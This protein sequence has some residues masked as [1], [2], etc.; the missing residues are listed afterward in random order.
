EICDP[1]PVRSWGGGG[2]SR[3]RGKITIEQVTGPFPIRAGDGGADVLD[4]PDALEAEGPHGP[5]HRAAGGAGEAFLAAEQGDPLPSPVQALG[6]HL[7]LSGDGVGRPGEVADLV[8]DQSVC[9][10]A[11]NDASRPL[12]GPVGAC[13]DRKALLTQDTKDRLDCIALGAHLVDERQDQRLRG[14]SSPAKKIEARR[15][16]SLSSRN[17]LTSDFRRL[18]SAWGGPESSRS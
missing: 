11:G 2:T 16:I 15:R 3:L 1:H 17:R 6:R 13:S 9:D 5:V 12:P 7:D 10:G 18:T 4:P 14:S 8:L